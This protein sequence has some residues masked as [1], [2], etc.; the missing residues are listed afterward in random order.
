VEKA[1]EVVS[2]DERQAMAVMGRIVK[3][4]IANSQQEDGKVVADVIVELADLFAKHS[5]RDELEGLVKSSLPYMCDIMREETAAEV[6]THILVL[7]CGLKCATD[8]QKRK[9]CQ[10]C[11]AHACEAGRAIVKSTVEDILMSEV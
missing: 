1:H 5:L 11:V 4:A 6:L 8:E 3:D 9:M 2:R 10:N 7:F